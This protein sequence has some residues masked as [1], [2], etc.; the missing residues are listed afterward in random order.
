MLFLSALQKKTNKQHQQ[1]HRAES[2]L[3]K[4]DHLSQLNIR[5]PHDTFKNKRS[6]N[7]WNTLLVARHSPVSTRLPSVTHVN[8]TEGGEH[9]KCNRLSSRR[10]SRWKPQSVLTMSHIGYN[11]R[12]D[13]DSCQGLKWLQQVFFL[14]FSHMRRWFESRGLNW[15]SWWIKVAEM[16]HLGFSYV[17]VLTKCY[18]DISKFVWILATEKQSLY[19]F[20]EAVA[21]PSILYPENQTG[22]FCKGGVVC[23]TDPRRRI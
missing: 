20:P 5:T 8:N 4:K 16:F 15:L 23:D 17:T 12:E 9:E 7:N 6:V 21:R 14:G 18:S 11:I 19:K 2:S 10:R 3:D 22:F 13:A 1:Q